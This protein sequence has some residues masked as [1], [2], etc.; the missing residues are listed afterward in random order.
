MLY[1]NLTD[2]SIQVTTVGNELVIEG[3]HDENRTAPNNQSS[4]HRQFYQKYTLP[5][6]CN[7]ESVTS[8]LSHNG[9]L[10]VTAPTRAIS[11]SSSP[12]PVPIQSASASPRLTVTKY[13]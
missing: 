3:K 9:V 8:Q 5:N 2:D 13:N 7:P 11:Y 4:A 1:S 6:G 10:T 12:R